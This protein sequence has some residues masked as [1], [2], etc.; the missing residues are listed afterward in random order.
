MTISRRSAVL[1]LS[2]LAL[3]AG[4]GEPRTASA[5]EDIPVGILLP[6]SG[7]VAPIGINNRR[8]HELAIEEI[9]A[10]G[11]I[12]SLGGA[13]LVMI[14]GDTQGN[15]NV[16]I[17]EVEKLARRGVVAIMGAYQSGVTF[18][19]TQMAERLRVPYIDPVAVAD[20]ITEGRGFKYTFKVSPLASWYARDQVRFV[21]DTSTAAGKPA[22]SVV[23][24]HEDTLFG[25]STAEGQ[26]KAAKEFGLEVLADIS[27]PKD[28]PD[29]TST[30]AQIK[31]LN[32]DA[33]LLVSYIN[34]AVLITKTMKELGVNIPIIGTSAGHIDPAYITNL[35]KDADLTFTVGEWN[36]DIEKAGAAEIAK[37]FEEKFSVP[38]NGHAA[39]TYMSTM[40]LRDALERA[41]STDRDK[42]RDALAETKICGDAN[43]LPYD[44]IRFGESGQS[45]EAQL[46]VLQI[47]DGVHKTV[48][49]AEVAAAQPTWPVPA[50]DAR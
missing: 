43:I 3:A 20:S 31:E 17:S 46:V 4:L 41:G 9:N 42:L 28:T 12:K 14:D 5:A 19:T 36:V 49:P 35:G 32:P 10:A 13:K 16:G 26:V 50:W 18:P 11:G 45:P 25:T 33:L 2:A 21:L 24:L 34:D 27:Y 15:P 39:E 47:I 8:G 44:C 38:M 7:S 23:L 29:M 37:R 40:V 30:I 1:A 6:L 22:K 48:W